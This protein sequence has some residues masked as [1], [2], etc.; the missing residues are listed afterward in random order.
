[1]QTVRP[2][3][4]R[5]GRRAE[6]TRARRR[7]DARCSGRG[8]A[9]RAAAL[10]AVLAQRRNVRLET[11]RSPARCTAGAGAVNGNRSA[12]IETLTAAEHIVKNA[13]V[14]SSPAFI[15]RFQ[16]TFFFPCVIFEFVSSRKS[17]LRSAH[18][19]AEAGIV[20]PSQDLADKVN[21]NL[22]CHL[23]TQLRP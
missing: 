22:P 20:R 8:A 18:V 12:R 14:E 6:V 10:S 3:A 15:Q 23:S 13:R 9:T 2:I 11:P 7:C 4:A 17:E 16:K 19:G 21:Y 5:R 1:M